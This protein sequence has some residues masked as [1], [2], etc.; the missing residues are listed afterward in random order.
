MDLGISA[1][2]WY[3]HEVAFS[4]WRNIPPVDYSTNAPLSAWYSGHPAKYFRQE[5]LQQFINEPDTV[6]LGIDYY[7]FY[8]ISCN[9]GSR[10]GAKWEIDTLLHGGVLVAKSFHGKFI[11]HKER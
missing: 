1:G 7:A 6:T 9:L 3:S 4:D 10:F 5:N 8:P 2:Q 11:I